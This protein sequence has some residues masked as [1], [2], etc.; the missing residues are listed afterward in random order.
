MAVMTANTDFDAIIVGGGLA[1]GL[2]ALALARGGMSVALI[3]AETPEA[4]QAEDFD[5]RT[6]AL[7]Y[8]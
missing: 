5:G 2:A 6:T 8:A 1:G 4:M 7:A 3:D